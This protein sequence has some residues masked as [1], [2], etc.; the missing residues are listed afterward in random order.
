MCNNASRYEKGTEF[1][2]TPSPDGDASAAAPRPAPSPLL[3]SSE[4]TAAACEASDFQNKRLSFSDASAPRGLLDL[5]HAPTPNITT[6]F[7]L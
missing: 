6:D 1:R 5:V 7:G 3:P 4:P 2:T